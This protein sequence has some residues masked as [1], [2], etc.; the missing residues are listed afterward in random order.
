MTTR[1]KSKKRTWCKRI[2]FISVLI[3]A[4]SVFS[5]ETIAKSDVKTLTNNEKITRGKG[6]S[7]ALLTEYQEIVNKYLEKYSVESPNKNDK[8]YWN[9]EFLPEEDWSRLYVIYFQMNGSQKEAQKIKFH[10]PPTLKSTRTPNA[11]L[12]DLW[13]NDDKSKIWINGECVEK[14]TLSSYKVADF[15]RDYTSSLFRSENKDEY[16]VDLWTKRGYNK[17]RKQFSKKPVSIEKL[18]EIE[19]EIV[20]VME[21]NDEKYIYMSRQ[22]I[23]GWSLISVDE[24]TKTKTFWGATKTNTKSTG[25]IGI[26]SSPLSY[27]QK[28]E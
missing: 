27:H 5:T 25:T 3:V 1:R 21:R 22:P 15:V 23:F 26:A 14:S 17:F 8:F 28:T 20:F 6:V 2:A 7:Q 4:I 10:G 12:Y 18:L 16:R 24:I 11:K 9:S 13:I 19:P